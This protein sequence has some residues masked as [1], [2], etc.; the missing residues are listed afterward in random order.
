MAWRN[1]TRLR[2]RTV[3]YQSSNIFSECNK[4]WGTF[5]GLSTAYILKKTVAGYF[6][7]LDFFMTSDVC[8][9]Q[10]SLIWLESDKSV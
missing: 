7:P 4:L 6:E 1:I 2:D 8:Y 9:K 5:I 3:N 10:K